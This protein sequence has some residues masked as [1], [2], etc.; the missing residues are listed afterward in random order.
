[1][2]T[3][4]RVKTGKNNTLLLVL[5]VIILLMLVVVVLKNISGLVTSNVKA[6]LDVNREI[7]TCDRYDNSHAISLTIDAGSD[8]LDNEFIFKSARTGEIIERDSLCGKQTCEGR[9]NKNFIISCNVPSGEYYFEINRICNAQEC[10]TFE[11]VIRSGIVE[12]THV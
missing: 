11:P 1:M 4:V 8:S 6:S 7:I 12:I 10:E 9:I 2:A 3:T 5:A